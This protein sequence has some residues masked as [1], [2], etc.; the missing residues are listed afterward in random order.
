MKSWYPS[1][2]IAAGLAISTGAIRT[3]AASAP[4]ASAANKACQAK[5]SPLDFTFKDS[6]LSPRFS[7]TAKGCGGKPASTGRFTFSAMASEQDGKSDELTQFEAS[8]KDV[9]GENFIVTPPKPIELQ[10]KYVKVQKLTK[11]YVVNCGCTN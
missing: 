4:T 6:K 2:F 9:K 10:N 11:I 3:Q 1:I 5:V 8:W 7:V